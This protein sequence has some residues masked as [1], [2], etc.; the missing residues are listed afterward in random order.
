MTLCKEID[1][2]VVAECIETPEELAAVIDAGCHLGQGLRARASR[3]SATVYGVAARLAELWKLELGAVGARR[4]T[5]DR[6]SLLRLGAG[7]ML[8]RDRGTAQSRSWDAMGAGC[9]LD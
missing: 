9:W 2:M 7:S 8:R 1:A 4:R 6:R 5:P 3:A